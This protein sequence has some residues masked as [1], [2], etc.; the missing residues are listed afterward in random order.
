MAK[1]KRL[2]IGHSVKKA[3]GLSATVSDPDV[4]A[5]ENAERDKLAQKIAKSR[6]ES[7][8]SLRKRPDRIKKYLKKYL[9]D[10]IFDEF[11]DS[12][13]KKAGASDYLKN[14]PIPLRKED[15]AGFHSDKGLPVDTIAKN[16]VQ[17]IGIDPAFPHTDAY[18]KYIEKQLGKKSQDY[19][20]K[21]GQR[22][23]ESEKFEPALICYRAAL[24]IKPDDPAAM[25]GYARSCRALYN[26]GED[27]TYIGEFKAESFEYFEMLTELH[28]RYAPGW[29]YLGYLYLN[30]GL[31]TKAFLAW[32]SFLSGSRDQK[33]KQEIRQRMEQLRTPMEIERGYNAVLAGRFQ[34]G[35]IILE[36]FTESVYREWWP[37]WY[38]LG[39][40]YLNTERIDEAEAAFKNTLRL[41]A[42]HIETME[43]LVT[44]YT[45]QDKQDLVKKYT[46]KIDLVKSQLQ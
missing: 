25:Y 12:Y 1:F 24:V 32:E 36:P 39:E 20:T 19:L 6:P 46:D 17:I 35:A 2:H 11:S 4:K 21:E 8:W 5:G 14:V 27:E 10:F 13:L 42:S 18:I 3:P 7:E 26:G 30:I 34:E 9:D 16:M 29:Y 45:A 33:D 44:I 43:E 40:S 38:Y 28:P 15:I 41:N 37:L 23:S 31:Y 22:E